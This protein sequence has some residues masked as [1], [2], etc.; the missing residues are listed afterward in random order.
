MLPEKVPFPGTDTSRKAK[1]RT[2]SRKGPLDLS[3]A[4]EQEI[5]AA[6]ADKNIL[7]YPPLLPASMAGA[8]AL[9]K[10]LIG[11]AMGVIEAC[12]VGGDSRLAPLCVPGSYTPELMDVLGAAYRIMTVVVNNH[13][14]MAQLFP[15][16]SCEDSQV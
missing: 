16:K 4:T 6:F 3:Q 2:V 15:T 14:V 1:R 11:G 8:I 12:Q 5:V 7:K 10:K 13:E 9:N